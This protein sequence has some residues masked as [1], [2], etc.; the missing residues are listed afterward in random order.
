M[1]ASQIVKAQLEA[2]VPRP[3]HSSERWADALSL[4]NVLKANN[5]PNS[6]FPIAN[7][8]A[9]TV[10]AFGRRRLRAA[11]KVIVDCGLVEQVSPNTR[12]S[13]AHY[14]WPRPKTGNR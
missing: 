1:G 8:M 12:H 9:D 5:G 3:P 6:V 7:A 11:R 13:P 4:L 14:R 10:I 2:P